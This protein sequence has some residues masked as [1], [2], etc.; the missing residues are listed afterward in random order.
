MFPRMQRFL[1]STATAALLLASSSVVPAQTA[2]QERSFS[3][4][5]VE[6]AFEATPKFPGPSGKSSR[7][8]TNWM[9]I[10]VTF[11]WQNTSATGADGQPLSTF[12]DE[13]ELDVFA[14]LNTR[15]SA[16]EQAALVTGKTTL[17][18]VP[19]GKDLVAVVYISPR[20]IDKLFN[21]KA[22]SNA[23][24]ALL[25][26]DTVGAVLKFNGEEV[27]VFPQVGPNQPPFWEN[28]QAVRLSDDLVRKVEDGIL[29]K[30]KTPFA[31]SNWDY[32]QEEKI[33]E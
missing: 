3:I 23:T 11:S 18:N 12:L 17:Q 20:L 1:L 5:K 13:L 25:G 30:S 33:G 26:K 7:A 4:S 6:A 10:E 21:G 2:N 19:E 28:L 27:A 22:P 29:P 24:G 9:Q 15:V 32:Y 8:K 14:L 31:F 16:T